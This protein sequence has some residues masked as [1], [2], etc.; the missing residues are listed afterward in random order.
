MRKSGFF[1]SLPIPDLPQESPGFP[2]WCRGIPGRT[3]SPPVC[4]AS[5]FDPATASA[6]WRMPRCCTP[7]AFAPG[8]TFPHAC[9]RPDGNYH[10]VKAIGQLTGAE[11][12]KFCGRSSP[13]WTGQSGA[14]RGEGASGRFPD[15][16]PRAWRSGNHIN[17]GIAEFSNVQP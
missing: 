1:S 9:R 14:G 4:P 5:G 8:P 11:I 2:A 3:L 16:E 13:G 17:P 15:R 6:R 10:C 12:R 7:L